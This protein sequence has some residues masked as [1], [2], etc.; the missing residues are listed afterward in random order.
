[1]TRSFAV[2]AVLFVFSATVGAAPVVTAISGTPADDQTVTINGSDFGTN[3]LR[4]TW[5][6]GATG[7]IDS[8]AN[9]VRIDSLGIAG[10]TLM[11]PSTNTYPHVSTERS[12][13]NGKSM[14][15]DV[16]NTDEYK[17]TLFLDIGSGGYNY[18]YTNAVIYFQHD[19]LANGSYLQWKM[20]RWTKS[21]TVVDG[22]GAYM[23]NR[24][25]ALA[26]FTH[27]SSAGQRTYWFDVAGTED[28]PGRGGWY[29]YETWLQ[30]NS[31]AGRSDGSFRVR[32]TNPTNG[33]VV[34]DNNFTD[35][36]YNGSGESGNFRYLVLQNYFGNATDSGANQPDNANAAAWWDDLYISQT[37]ARVELC[38]SA[39]YAGCTNKE[40]QPASSWT[41]GSI[42]IKVNRGGITGAGDTYIYVTNPNGEVNSQGFRLAAGIAPNPP[43]SVQVQ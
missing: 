10:L 28:L 30:M 1:M 27:F 16:R 25:N 29:R 14:A 41:N 38:T 20:I 24:P 26:F 19:N 2:A 3:S 12:W 22:D 4:Q 40:I 21:P 32:V 35:V 33:N 37:Q 7:I 5:F 9:G 15:F 34:A 18:L 8:R 36:A 42:A 17:Q 31:A 43:S 13:S 39:T 11:Q 23:A 6:G